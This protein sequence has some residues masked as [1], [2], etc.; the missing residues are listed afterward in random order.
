[1]FNA[2]L[3]GLPNKI[4]CTFTLFIYSCPYLQF[5]HKVFLAKVLPNLWQRRLEKPLLLSSYQTITQLD[6]TQC[7]KW[8]LDLRA[9]RPLP[10]APP[11]STL[12]YWYSD[13]S[14]N[15]LGV[16]GSETHTCHCVN[17]FYEYCICH[18]NGGNLG[19]IHFVRYIKMNG[20]PCPYQVMLW[21]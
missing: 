7:D 19:S 16:S 21:G 15:K 14:G 1:M 9:T 10:S 12:P 17:L 2:I 18:C 11:T 13:I 5:L 8:I 3:Y 20:L 4:K 6:F